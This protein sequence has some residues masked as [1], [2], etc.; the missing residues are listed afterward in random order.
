MDEKSLQ[1]LLTDVPNLIDHFERMRELPIKLDLAPTD[2]L[3]RIADAVSKSDDPRREQ[4]LTYL[5]TEI[6]SRPQTA[7]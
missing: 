5:R 6:N 2:D 1:G 4:M 7:P 3:R